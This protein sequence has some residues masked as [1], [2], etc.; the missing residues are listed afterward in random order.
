MLS[1]LSPAILLKLGM[2]LVSV[3]KEH[4]EPLRQQA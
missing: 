2:L 3:P 1:E 4:S